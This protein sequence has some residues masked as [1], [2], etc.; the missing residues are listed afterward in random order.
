MIAHLL[1]LTLAAAP[2]GPT[3]VIKEGNSEVQKILDSADASAEKLAARAE[4][5]VDFGELARRA[6]GK[7]WNKL[8][9][10]QQDEFAQTM[11]GLLRASYAQKAIGDGKGGATTEY[12]EEKITGNEAV[13]ATTLVMK[14]DRFPV[15]YRLYRPDA[16]GPWRIYDVVTDAVSLVST[17]QD[18]FRQ[19]IAKKGYDGL[20][21]TLKAKRDQLEKNQVEKTQVT[22]ATTVGTGK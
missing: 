17:Y 22:P 20:L 9:K 14:K 13:V 4:E 12:G 16:K 5:F 7:E 2:A 21:S 11:K 15:D 3:G 8:N 6:L 1:L 18:Q 19:L 10:K